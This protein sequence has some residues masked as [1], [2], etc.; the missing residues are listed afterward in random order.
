M[1]NKSIDIF[2]AISIILVTFFHLGSAFGGPGMDKSGFAL[3]NILGNGWIG[4]GMF[5]VISGFCM[6]ASTQGKFSGG[7]EKK[8]YL[9]YVLNRFL[10]IAPA[11]YVSMIF[12]Y[13][14]I[15]EY[16]VVV[17][18]VAAFDMLT[19]VFFVHN[20]FKETMFSVSGV[21]WT[22]A[23][24]MQFYLL[25]PVLLSVLTTLPKQVITLGVTL[26]LGLAI[27]ALSNNVVCIFGL[28]VYLCL[29]IAGVLSYLHRE[30]I[31]NALSKYG[32]IWVVIAL[33]VIMIFSQ[34]G[35][36]QNRV[37]VF[38][39]IIS[40]LFALALAYASVNE[41]Y[42][43]RR[44]ILS[45]TMAFI[46]R[47]S[48]SIYLYNYVMHALP[49]EHSGMYNFIIIFI[50]TFSAGVIAHF[51]IEKPFEKL[52]KGVMRARTSVVSGNI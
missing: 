2:R 16:D 7:F 11:Y 41:R 13:F 6:G 43:V 32:L 12:W 45:D 27:A 42:S 15:T 25:L 5:F 26:I 10:R 46:G 38:E 33:M 50:V 22:L 40:C 1:R 29:F 34:Y 39:I 28:P 36:Y 20:F 21:Y 52:R 17:K 35:V 18:P 30:R 37:R 3:G 44:N 48:F 19:H 24:E 49:I 9:R 47:C 31:F 14:I 51:V 23:A 4:V 8:T